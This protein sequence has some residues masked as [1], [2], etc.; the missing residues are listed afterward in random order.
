MKTNFMAHSQMWEGM[1]GDERNEVERYRGRE[2]ERV[3]LLLMQAK[4]MKSGENTCIY[5]P[6]LQG[7]WRIRTLQHT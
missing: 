3:G 5:T 4:M 7:K 2:R 1:R 6:H